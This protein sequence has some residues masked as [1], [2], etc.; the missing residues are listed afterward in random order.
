MSQTLETEKMTKA[1]NRTST[2]EF[3]LKEKSGDLRSLKLLPEP[4]SEEGWTTVPEAQETQK[5]QKIIEKRSKIP[6]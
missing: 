6:A 5:V 3:S 4:P 2:Q 1:F